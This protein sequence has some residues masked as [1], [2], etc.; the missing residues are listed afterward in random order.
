MNLYNLNPDKKN[1]QL[2]IIQT[3]ETKNN[4]MQPFIVKGSSLTNN[5]ISF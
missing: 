4:N 3:A 2:D 1:S 5:N